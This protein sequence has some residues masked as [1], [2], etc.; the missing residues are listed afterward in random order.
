LNFSDD[1]KVEKDDISR[2]ERKGRHGDEPRLVIPSE[3]EGSKK[4]FSLWSK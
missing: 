2:K 3:C 4:D 1:E